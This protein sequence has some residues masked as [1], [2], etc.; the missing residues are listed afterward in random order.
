MWPK[1]FKIESK[2]LWPNRRITSLEHIVVWKLSISEFERD[3][4]SSFLFAMEGLIVIFHADDQMVFANIEEKL[5]IF[6]NSD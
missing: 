1:G 6:L 3:R 2:L 5:G 4:S